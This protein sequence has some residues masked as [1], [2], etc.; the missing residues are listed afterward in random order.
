MSL[1]AVALHEPQL[2]GATQALLRVL[3]ALEERGWSF[4]FWVPGRGL[5]EAELR[6]NG[7]AA[8]CAEREL[9]FSLASLREPPGIARRLLTVPGYLERWR[10]WLAAQD[11]ALLHANSVLTLPELVSRPRPGPPVVLHT[12]EVLPPGPK[13][14]VAALL[15]RQ[16]DAVVAV[17]N[18]AASALGRRRVE[19][20]VVHPAVPMPEAAPRER[21]EGR[22]VVGTLGTVCRRKGSELFVAAAERVRR[23]RDGL[24]FRM[25]GGLVVGG[26]R[27]WAQGVVELA[28]RDGIVHKAW[29]DPYAE[30]AD[31]DIFVLPARSDPFPLAVLEAMTLGLPVVGTRVDGIPEQLGDAGLLVESED[32][33]ALAAAILRLA[34]SP[35]LRDALGDA[36]RRR[37]Q[38]EFTLDRQ[39]DGLDRVYRDVLRRTR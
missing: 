31:W 24:E 39:A 25:A 10:A 7:Y 37:V 15:S 11:A 17:S 5:A 26:E 33:D 8:A 22:L 6:R 12:H 35:E 30:M 21:R 38:R 20:T 3:P 18:A 34:D 23:Q 19:A 4:T 28:R 29:V 14:S 27:A 2:G 32:V 9:R 36:A 1:V 16:A 13:G